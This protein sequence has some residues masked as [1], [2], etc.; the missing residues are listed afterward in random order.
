[1]IYSTYVIFTPDMICMIYTS[2]MIYM[3]YIP[4]IKS[5]PDIMLD[6]R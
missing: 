4:D 1:M 3:I 5:A 2:D 6:H